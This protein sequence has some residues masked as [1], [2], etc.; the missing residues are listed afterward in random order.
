MAYFLAYRV[1]Y[2]MVSVVRPQRLIG[3]NLFGIF[4]YFWHIL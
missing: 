2:H 3:A 1:E 4:E